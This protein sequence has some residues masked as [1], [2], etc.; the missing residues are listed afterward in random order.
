[1]KN[2]R[3][4]KAGILFAKMPYMLAAVFTGMLLYNESVL[5]RGKTH[6][7]VITGKEIKKMNARKISDVLN[8]VPGINAGETSVSIRGSYRVKV[9]LD[10]RPIND[11]TS[12]H[13]FVKFDLVSLENVERIEIYRGKGAL[14]YG[15]DASGGVI[16]IFSKKTDAFH[17]NIRSYWGNYGTSNYSANCRA[18]NG[19]FGVGASLGY[20]YTDGYQVNGDR[21]KKKAGGKFEYMPKN[22][23]KLTFSAAY[24][25][26]QRGLSGRPEYPTP[27]SRK[28]SEMYS[29]A[30]SARA[31]RIT[32]E[33]FFNDAETK[34]RDPDRNIDNS[35]TVRKFGE[36]ISTSLEGG[37]W[38]TISCGAAFRWGQAES[39]RFASKDEH[40]ISL[41]ATNTISFGPLPISISFGLRGS[42]YSDFDNTL[43]PEA[44]IFCKTN[45]SSISMTYSRTNNT[46]SFYQRYD[47]TSTKEPNPGLKMETADN[48]SLSF[49][50]E[51]SPR[52]SCGASVFYNRIA[53]RI[54]YVL[55][56]DGIG[57]YE[58][59]GEVTYKGG[60]ISLNWKIMEDLSL[61]TTYTY[62]E[63]I[64]E[65]TGL[66]M[67]AKPRHRVYAD[68]SCVPIEDLSIIFNLK[69]ESRQYTR[70]DNKASVPGR[71]IGNIRLEYHPARLAG[72]FGA[73][74][75][76]GEIKNI[77][78]K[79]YRYGDGWLAP[80]RTW[81]VGLNYRF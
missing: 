60:D 26:D 50:T 3:N 2:L 76:F 43:N 17:G 30:L 45:K 7:I 41:Y 24:L 42:G 10:G 14:K 39:S 65:D 71:A 68:L 1:M 32:S 18:A 70:S 35:I 12:S 8:Q 31:K 36:D 55:G 48:F 57:R 64:N 37:G 75:F 63:A 22:G 78:N 27:H 77:A 53:G 58:N 19:A 74:E 51:V 20:E 79:A 62:L 49:F 67:V 73:P 61:K 15:D 81:T 56:D 5:A 34:N 38:G 9:L 33:T 11:P 46:P 44:K 59:F 47:K 23:L 21:K 28:Q 25:K 13:G 69:Y 6:A 16:L 40:S 52:L 66:W 72:R 54:A 4:R 80:P 29:Y